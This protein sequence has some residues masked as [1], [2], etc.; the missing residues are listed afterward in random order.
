MGDI[1]QL[2]AKI[3]EYERVKKDLKKQR[4]ELRTH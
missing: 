3:A 2:K 4:A 1:P